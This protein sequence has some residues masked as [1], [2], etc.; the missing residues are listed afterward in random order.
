MSYWNI[1]HIKNGN[2][3]LDQIVTMNFKGNIRH[4]KKEDIS[5]KSFI[6]CLFKKIYIYILVY[7][8]QTQFFLDFNFPTC[9]YDSLSN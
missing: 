9:Q 2:I 7:T 1:V 8:N 4:W 3:K 5:E 6:N